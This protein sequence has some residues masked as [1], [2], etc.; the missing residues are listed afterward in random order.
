MPNLISANLPL[1]RFIATGMLALLP[2]G[3]TSAQS[4]QYT[5]FE[6]HD[7]VLLELPNDWNIVEG[8]RRPSVAELAKTAE[9][10]AG[11]LALVSIISAD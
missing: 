10:L 1:G 4:K 6:V 3:Q 11:Q 7:Q 5:M 8:E 9:T 2:L